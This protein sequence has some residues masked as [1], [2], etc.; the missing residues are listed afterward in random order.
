VERLTES[1][2]VALPKPIDAPSEERA[3]AFAGT[4]E[5]E[6]RVRAVGSSA[7][8][9]FFRIPAWGLPQPQAH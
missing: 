1:G 7:D 3:V 9:E 2:W 4:R 5:G 8:P 6:Y